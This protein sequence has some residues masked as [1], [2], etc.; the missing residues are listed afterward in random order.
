MGYSTRSMSLPGD[1]VCTTR[2]LQGTRQDICHTISV[3]SH[4]KELLGDTPGQRFNIL[5]GSHASSVY[6]CTGPG[7]SPNQGQ[8]RGWRTI[9]NCSL[10]SSQWINIVVGCEQGLDCWQHTYLDAG[11]LPMYY[12]I[13]HSRCPYNVHS[14]T[15][16]T[17]QSHH[18]LIWFCVALK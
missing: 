16:L 12:L 5:D 2:W 18:P 11:C 14:N 10:Q 1:F 17:E 6:K 8:Y 13:P 3:N 7:P 4:Y 9:T 15:P